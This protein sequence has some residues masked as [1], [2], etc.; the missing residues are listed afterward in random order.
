M[1]KNE[2]IRLF[3]GIFLGIF[4]VV[5]GALFIF[6]AADLYYSGLAET[7]HATGMY[8][9]GEVASR[10]KALL[11]PLLIWVAAVIAGGVLF[12]R[13]P[14]AG[15]KR[16]T[17]AHSAFF[18]L[19]R[20]A[21]RFEGGELGVMSARLALAEKIR[22]AVW[23]CA[24]AFCAAAAVMSALY[25]FDAA[26]FPGDSLNGEILKMLGGVLPWL[27]AAFAA[28]AACTACEAVYAKKMLPAVKKL[29]AAGRGMPPEPSV[30][31]RGRAAGAGLLRDP[32]VIAG[33][34]IAVF[35]AAVTLIAVGAASGEARVM[36]VKAINICTECIGLG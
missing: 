22:F 23:A 12:A 9:R 28:V 16:R 36:W 29:V 3:Y 21:P 1:Q 26:N 20:R 13:F 17:D 11:A 35:A 15:I 8:S 6:E 30:W 2:K 10:L 31:E 33:V 27:G 4:T 34:R 7:G 18:R 5:I 24:A 19:K 25:V 14:A 32:R